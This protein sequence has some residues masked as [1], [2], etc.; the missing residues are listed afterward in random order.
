MKK[1][2]FT[3]VGCAAYLAVIFI[4]GVLVGSPGLCQST[5]GL[6]AGRIVDSISGRAVSGARIRWSNRAT[7]LSA[8]VFSG[9]DGYYYLTQLSPGTYA[10]RVEA[11][12][13]QAREA[14]EVEL[15]VAARL[16]WNIRLRPGHDVWEQGTSRSVF[17]PGARVVINFYGPDVDSTKWTAL[18]TQ[19]PNTGALEATVSEVI[20]P[21]LVD[22]LPFEGRDVYAALSLLPGVTSDAATGRGLGLVANGQRPYSANFLLDGLELNN[23]LVSGPLTPVVPEAVQEYRVSTTNYLAQYGGASGLVANAV[24]RAGGSHFHGS[25]YSYLQNKLFDATDFQRNRTGFGRRSNHILE[26]GY[27]LGGPVLKRVPLFFSSA[28]EH[29][30]MRTEAPAPTSYVLPTATFVSSLPMD[31]IARRL[32]SQYPSPGMSV[33]GPMSAV[34]ALASPVKIDRYLSMTRLDYTPSSTERLS[35]SAVVSRTSQPG[36]MWSPYVGLNTDFRQYTTA[37]SVTHF[38]TLS[39]HFSN[40]LKAGYGVDHTNWDRAHSEIPLLSSSDGTTLP[41]NPGLYSYGHSAPS[42]QLLDNATWSRDRHILTFGGGV[43]WRWLSGYLTPGRDGEFNFDDLASFGKD[44]PIQYRTSRSYAALPGGIQSQV[45]LDYDR[46]YRRREFSAFVQETYRATARLTLNLGLRYEWFGGPVNIGQ[47]KDPTLASGSGTLLENQLATATVAM[48]PAGN[49]ALFR[50]TATWAPRLGVA[51]SLS[52]KGSTVLR[53]GFGVFRDRFYDVLLQTPRLNDLVFPVYDI[54]GQS[55]NYLN[56]AR[57]IPQGALPIGGT[58]PTRFTFFDPS[59]PAIRSYNYFVG[60]QQSVGDNVTVQVDAIGA[61]GRDLI[62]TNVVNRAPQSAGDPAPNS[63]IPLNIRYRAGQGDSDYVGLAARLRYRTRFADFHL[64]YTWSHSIDNQSQPLENDLLDFAGGRSTVAPGF[65]QPFNIQADRGNSDFDQRHSLVFYSVWQSPVRNSPGLL[66]MLIRNWKLSQ[67][68]AFRSGY[69]YSVYSTP[70]VR[71][72]IVDSSH[73]VLG[74]PVA[75]NGGQRILN[76]TAFATPQPGTMGNSGRNA[77]S[78]PRFYSADVSVQRSFA[79]PMFRE[80]AR[81]VVRADAFNFLNHPNLNVPDNLLSSST[82]G[83][84]LYGHR[85]YTTGYVAT[86]PLDD[87]AR[88]IQLS[89]KVEF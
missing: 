20:T 61:S 10:I 31:G 68:A 16:E 15:P 71:A 86:A 38:L 39:S 58:E 66:N 87:C 74:T 48:P 43:L 42:W 13:F 5:Q 25:A 1:S 32:L 26:S 36:F 53:A 21:R 34:F 7:G 17:L 69:P 14:R 4:L 67:L 76:A 33:T 37:L 44:A 2:G 46:N 56:Y 8:S 82:F 27:Q 72:D 35:A 18:E 50:S 3:G 65:S 11:E 85:G 55:I 75:V 79:L 78:G 84:A 29:F 73:T 57:A 81:L 40:E 24:T 28:L 88:R 64:S 30:G 54:R 49:Q 23:Y 62:T 70:G 41:S 59:L 52:A 47:T 12:G 19:K 9:T 60:I 77:F 89:L 63:R 45:P 80:S 83:T 51:Y 22:S 6:I